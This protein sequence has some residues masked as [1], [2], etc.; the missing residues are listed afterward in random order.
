MK[1]IKYLKS[2]F[3]ETPLHF[4]DDKMDLI[5]QKGVYPYDQMDFEDKY[6]ETQLPPKDKFYNKFNE[7]DIKLM[8]NINTLKEFGKHL[9]LKI[10]VNMQIYMLKQMLTDIFENFRDERG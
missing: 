3:R 2:Q 7:C 10:Q 4:P 8:K 9:M 6:K 5:R 1:Y